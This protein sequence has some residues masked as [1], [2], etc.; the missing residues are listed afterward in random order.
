SSRRCFAFLMFLWHWLTLPQG[1]LHQ[2][3]CEYFANRNTC[4]KMENCRSC[5]LAKERELEGQTTIL[6][7]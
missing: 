2:L 1:V 6:R 4:F 5:L 7:L 3:Q